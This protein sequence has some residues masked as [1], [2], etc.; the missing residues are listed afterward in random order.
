LALL[1]LLI[2]LTAVTAQTP[3][4]KL[5]ETHQRIRKAMDASDLPT[6]LNELRSLRDSDATVFAANNYDYLLGRLSERAGDAAG[7]QAGYEP[8]VARKS[9]L[10]PYAIWRLAQLA[11]SSGDL[12]LERERLRQFLTSTTASA[13]REAAVLRLGESLWES[14]DF[15]AIPNVLRPLTGSTS[16]PV[17]REGMT[18]TA[19]ALLRT[20]RTQE[21]R[22]LFT[23]VLMQMPDAS[24]PDD[25]ALAAARALDSLDS[26]AAS[27]I[28]NS[29]AEDLL[30]A[31]VYQF[32]RDFDGARV[33]YLAVVEQNPKSPTVPNALYQ[34][35]RGYYLQQRYDEAIKY[36]QR[37][38]NE[39]PESNSARDAI[40]FTA[41]SYNRMRRPDDAL[42][43]YKL[44]IARFPEGPNLDRTYLNIVDT[45]HE[46]ARYR[47]ALDWVRQT[48]T[49]FN[50]QLGATL[51][52]FAQMRIHLAQ[53]LWS[54]VIA[55][56]EELR[57]VSD[58]GGT[59]VPGG[60][61]T[62]E[63]T[64]LQALALEQWGKP[65]EAVEL[66]LS[67]PDGRNEYYG[68][69]ATDRLQA[70]AGAAATS[71][72]ITRREQSLRTQA[73]Q[74]LERGQADEARTYANSALRLGTEATRKESIELLKRAYQSLPAYALRQPALISLG[75]QSVINNQQSQSANPGSV[76]DELLFLGLFDEAVPELIAASANSPQAGSSSTTATNAATRP[77]GLSENEYTIAMLALRGGL[78][79]VA[80][81]FGERLWR[82]MPA[83][84][85][86]ELAPSQLVDLL[87]PVPHRESLLKHAPAR[88][89]D[90]RFVLS[91]ARQESRF[92][93][94]VKSVAAA[95]GM[96]QF[97]PSTAD[98]VAKQLGKSDFH[99]NELYNPDTAVL[100]G[101]QY[102]ASLFR[103][104][105]SEPEAVAAAYNG[106]SD[107]IARWI[108]R[109]RSKDSERYVAE[110]GFAQTKDY[111]FRVMTNFRAYQRFYDSNLRRQ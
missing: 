28:T 44:L 58:L 100:F 99:Q 17:A 47:E 76:A 59:R 14:G 88:G 72:L 87:Y 39:F 27:R 97:I 89:V 55:D 106:G 67:L 94:G 38:Y 110:V 2:P 56:A 80:V 61:T 54:E 45:L 31:S 75:R 85:A 65:A 30:R 50:G 15:S 95:R 70:L 91:I 29:E 86:L 84:F 101:S 98:E 96:M 92:Q 32:N 25:F 71:T 42:T 66:Y 11:R 57:K 102:L 26:S 46:A 104:F 13:L 23:Q 108:A 73:Q 4:P 49:R 9:I 12:V 60:T 16:K 107:N 35:G 111:I 78:A 33:H 36:F 81:R 105:P 63:V 90:P 8:V 93:A 20:G 74:A 43:A 22:E 82:T 48:R 62:A 69:R 41:G 7:A 83:D 77:A 1:L 5:D 68:Q 103:E 79:E 24:R 52:L 109:S 3:Q 34:A 21:A 51:A 53:G 37:V 64:F 18:L 10:A 40:A 19:Q 6:A